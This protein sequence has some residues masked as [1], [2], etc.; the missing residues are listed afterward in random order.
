MPGQA[1]KDANDALRAAQLLEFIDGLTD[2]PEQFRS[3]EESTGN[4]T[5]PFKWSTPKEITAELLPVSKLEPELI[6][7]PLRD[8]LADIAHRMQVPLDFPATASIVMLSSIIGTQLSIRPKKLDSW[9]VI[10]NLWGALIQRPSSIK[11]HP[12][13][14]AFRVLEK[15]EAESFK[16]NEEDE[17]IYQNEIRK[18]E[19]KQKIYEDNLRKAIKRSENIEISNAENALELLES[20]PPR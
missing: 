13:K 16:Q 18:F 6:P 14:E 9:Q 12:V 17:K 15:L 10:P 5:E 8:W 7:E 19:M 1:G 3:D 11:S 20:A 2:I 4:T